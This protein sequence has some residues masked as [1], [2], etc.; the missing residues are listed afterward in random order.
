MLLLG[1]VGVAGWSALPSQAGLFAV[2]SS[3]RV[4]DVCTRVHT[5][6]FV[7]VFGL[8]SMMH[9]VIQAVTLQHA[10]AVC[11]GVLNRT[12]DFLGGSRAG[13]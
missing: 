10:T 8:L 9:V 6:S 2:K 5:T 4:S 7:L 3:V 12:A 1:R 13:S 11:T